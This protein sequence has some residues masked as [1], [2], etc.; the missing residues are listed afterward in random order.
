MNDS[1]KYIR[2][3]IKKAS[4]SLWPFG[5]V[6]V[7][8][9]EIISIAGA[10]D[11]TDYEHDPTAHAET[12]AIRRASQKLRTGNLEGA[13]LYASCEP[14]A[15]CFGAAWYAGI[16]KIVY[17]SALSDITEI[18]SSW[19]GD[20]EFPHEHIQNTGINVEAGILKEEVMQ[21][22]QKHPRVLKNKR[23]Q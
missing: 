17:G 18:N 11:G 9:G 22:Y 20:L 21:M 10:G 14:C 4:E 2:M 16:K 3:A 23:N 13:I 8:D 1:E 15:L 7:K 12:N 19:G 5:A 6:I